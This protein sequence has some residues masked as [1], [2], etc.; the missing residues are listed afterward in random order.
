M[1]YTIELNSAH[2]DSNQVPDKLTS[3]SPVVEIFAAMAS[4]TD[5]KRKYGTTA[6]KVVDHIKNLAEQA[7]IGD[8]RAIA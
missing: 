1:N 3:K 7:D 5:I 4:G 2:L 8:F 6:N